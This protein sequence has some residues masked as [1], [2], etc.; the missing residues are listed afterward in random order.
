M[1][2]LMKIVKF[3][4]SIMTGLWARAGGLSALGR[5]GETGA[6]FT[7]RDH[8]PGSISQWAWPALG[9]D[10]TGGAQRCRAPPAGRA[11]LGWVLFPPALL[12]SLHLHRVHLGGAPALDFTGPELRAV[13]HAAAREDPCEGGARTARC[14]PGP[15]PLPP[16]TPPSGTHPPQSTQGPCRWR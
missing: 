11:E 6:A 12:G 15:S 2:F 14:T 1:L 16:P 7:P 9:V 4:A 3:S 8:L 5:R 13:V 10:S